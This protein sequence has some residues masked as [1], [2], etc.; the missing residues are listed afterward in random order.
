MANTLDFE[1]P[2][3][4]PT[5]EP[6]TWGTALSTYREAVG[7]GWEARESGGVPWLN[8]V[9]FAPFGC[10]LPDATYDLDDPCDNTPTETAPNLEWPEGVD[11]ADDCVRFDPFRINHRITVPVII[12]A[13]L[14]DVR[15]RLRLKARIARS[16]SVAREAM[17]SIKQA[18]NPS[19]VDNATDVTADMYDTTPTAALA[20]VENALAARLV[21]GLGMIHVDPGTLTLLAV[22][23]G[24][25][26]DGAQYRTATGHYVV[27]D[28]GYSGGEPASGPGAPGDVT[29]GQRWIYG[30]GLVYYKI[31]DDPGLVAPES[32]NIAKN[33]ATFNDEA[34][35]IVI[36]EPCTVVAAKYS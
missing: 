7:E 10:D 3:A 23:G 17:H 29:A 15:A 30:S 8:G 20:A 24:L 22:D 27:G 28:A 35:A 32:F 31:T 18:S 25:N 12:G 5:V 1:T 33:R 4:A 21:D 36:F 34:Y 2:V 14:D 11:T 6:R 19:F 13:P 16:Y 9:A 26:F